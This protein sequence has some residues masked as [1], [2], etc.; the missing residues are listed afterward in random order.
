[1]K[2]TVAGWGFQVG[3]G[4]IEDTCM[5]GIML[6]KERLVVDISASGENK[7]ATACN[8]KALER[9]VMLEEARCFLDDPDDNGDPVFDP[10]TTSGYGER[11]NHCLMAHVEKPILK[12]AR[13]GSPAGTSEA[14]FYLRPEMV[15]QPYDMA[16]NYV[17][18]MVRGPTVETATS[19]SYEL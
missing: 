6:P 3:D 17:L 11:K 15:T 4:L 13:P 19:A 12:Q 2:I 10:A 1:M 8:D 14:V 16:V 9:N 18:C 5:M 7:P